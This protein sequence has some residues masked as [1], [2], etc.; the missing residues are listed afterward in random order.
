ML[1]SCMK[2]RLPIITFLNLNGTLMAH[3]QM[4]KWDKCSGATLPL[5][6]MSC[7][8]EHGFDFG[9]CL[10]GLSGI[11]LDL[12]DEVGQLTLIFELK[13]KIDGLRSRS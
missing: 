11:L 10:T 7:Y 8:Y 1:V 4:T 5:A 12:D 9:W 3:S 6:E 13:V 2:S